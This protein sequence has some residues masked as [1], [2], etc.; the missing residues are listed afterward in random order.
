MLEVE[1][2]ELKQKSKEELILMLDECQK[3]KLAAESKFHVIN[4]LD[5][6]KEY[7]SLEAHIEKVHENSKNVTIMMFR[8]Y[9][10]ENSDQ[11]FSSAVSRNIIKGVTK[12]LKSHIRNTDIL[13]KYNEQNFV[14]IAPNTDDDGIYKYATKLNSIITTHEFGTIS[15]L[16]SNFTTTLFNKDDSIQSVIN[17]L[18]NSLLAVEKNNKAHVIQV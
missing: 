5:K 3:S 2:N 13:I 4:T 16:Q 1:I 11:I 8:I 9:N 6:L 17:R 12:L 14:I 10:L 15:H 7:P 18:F